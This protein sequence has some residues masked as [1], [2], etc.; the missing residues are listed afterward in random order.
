MWLIRKILVPVDFSDGS[1]LALDRALDV[2]AQVGASVIAM[3]ATGTQS[4][5]SAAPALQSVVDARRKRG[6]EIRTELREGAAAVAVVHAADD[7]GA[8]LIVVGSNGRTGLAR[9][10]LGSVAEEIARSATMPVL[11]VHAREGVERPA[12]PPFG[13][14]H[15]AGVRQP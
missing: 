1:E 6:V 13:V 15:E 5:A 14:G 3:H 2:A 8:D 10:V 11:I 12:A 4:D 7:L 9:S